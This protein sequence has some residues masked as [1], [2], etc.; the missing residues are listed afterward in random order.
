MHVR[1]FSKQI[2]SSFLNI[3]I[4]YGSVSYGSL[5]VLIR[6]CCVQ[7]STVSYIAC[8]PRGCL[9]CSFLN[10][11][12]SHDISLSHEATLLSNRYAKINRISQAGKV[13]WVSHLDFLN[14]LFSTVIFIRLLS[15]AA[16]YPHSSFRLSHFN[17]L[18]QHTALLTCSPTL[19]NH[20]H[21][22]IS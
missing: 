18:V 12:P 8:V 5:S 1:L 4:S 7:Y 11:F 17:H 19:G 15:Y 20:H 13:H 14:R 3:D 22:T 6:Q 9:G 21:W 16:S 2:N 10:G